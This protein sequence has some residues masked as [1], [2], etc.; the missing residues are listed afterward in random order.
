MN[1]VNPPTQV[2]LPPEIESNQ[3]LK[4]AFDDSYYIMFQMWKRLGGGADWVDDGRQVSYE[5]DD[6]VF[7]TAKEQLLSDVVST[8]VGYTSIGDQTIICT[9]AL[10]V[11]LNAEPSDQELVKVIIANGDVTVDGNGRLINKKPDV[12]VIFKNL[13]T[14][15]T[16]DIIY[17]IE[18]DEWFII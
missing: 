15:A 7:N 5:F 14:L 18:L 8:A 4:K 10:P 16:L 11:T 9:A 17:I 3:Q 2:R 1:K 13:S 6:L 12:T